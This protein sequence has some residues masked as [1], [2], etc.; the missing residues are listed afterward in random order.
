[1]ELRFYMPSSWPLMSLLWRFMSDH[2]KCYTFLQMFPFRKHRSIFVRSLLIYGRASYLLR[3][4]TMR[5]P[6]CKTILHHVYSFF[7][8]ASNVRGNSRTGIFAWVMQKLFY[9]CSIVQ[10]SMIPLRPGVF[11][12][13]GI[14]FFGIWGQVFKVRYD[15]LFSPPLLFSKQSC[16]PLRRIRR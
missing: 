6:L 15:L 8:G 16:E 2:Q 7:R 14:P 4:Q 10:R 3:D 5:L 12:Q 1:M 11:Q 9:F 13:Q